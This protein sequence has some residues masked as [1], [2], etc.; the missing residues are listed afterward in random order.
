MANMLNLILRS[1]CLWKICY[2]SL[3]LGFHKYITD[4]FFAW[5]NVKVFFKNKTHLTFQYKCMEAK[6]FIAAQMTQRWF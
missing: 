4:T 6:D 2:N 1:I 5:P 3:P